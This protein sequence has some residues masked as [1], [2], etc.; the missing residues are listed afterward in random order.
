M[1]DI[2]NFVFL[3]KEDN[4]GA[5][6]IAMAN[7]K[8]GVAKTT[9]TMNLGAA[10]SRNGKKVLLVDCDPQANLT[11]I[12]GYDEPEKLKTTLST[13]LL[14]VIREEPIGNKEG[15]LIHAEGM[16]LMPASEELA[17]TEMT[18]HNVMSRETVL[19][20]YI[21]TVK[22]QYDYILIDCGPSLELLTINALTASNSVVI[23]V[24]SHYLPT[25]G[26]QKLLKTIARTRRN[27]NPS[28]EIEGILLTMVDSR[29]N[30]AREIC[31]LI[32]NTYAQYV[33]D[34]EI[35]HSIRL[36]EMAVTGE[37]IFRYE[38]KGRTAEAYER[39]A[40][41]V[42]QREKTIRKS[43]TEQYR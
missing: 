38:P 31:T 20:Q 21:Q 12:M 42:M 43:K 24:L 16:D 40:K 3:L 22:N 9:S 29:T 1:N 26:L 34:A 32:R 36:A 41:E 15:I 27:L 28:L 30:F 10:L 19:K 4:M 17:T 39:L 23:P 13:V 8:G 6:V 11:E 14:K 33:F 37:S 35:P 7:Q 18:L 25:K 5:K 2:H